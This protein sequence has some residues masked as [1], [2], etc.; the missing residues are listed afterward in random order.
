[1]TKKS[2]FCKNED[3]HKPFIKNLAFVCL[4]TIVCMIS[5]RFLLINYLINTKITPTF[6]TQQSQINTNP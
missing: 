6:T 1:M 2:G 4:V 3:F 5:T